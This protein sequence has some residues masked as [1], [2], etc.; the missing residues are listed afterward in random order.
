MKSLRKHR[1][2]LC[3][4][5][6]LVSLAPR[7]TLAADEGFQPEHVC[8]GD[9]RQLTSLRG[10]VRALMSVGAA[11]VA[12]MCYIIV[13]GGRQVFRE[14]QEGRLG[15]C[16]QAVNLSESSHR[17]CLNMVTEIRSLT[18]MKMDGLSGPTLERQINAYIVQSSIN[19]GGNRHL[20][21]RLRRACDGGMNATPER[22]TQLAAKVAEL[23]TCLQNVNKEIDALIRAIR[24][25]RAT[26]APT[27]TPASR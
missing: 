3:L 22:K 19:S 12:V 8:I 5:L 21:R 1:L 18:S 7:V 24:E 27:A 20:L 25:S 14:Y 2:L 9:P 26:P 17:S 11:R 23:E 4:A 13:A 10:S 16:P 15:D 6:A